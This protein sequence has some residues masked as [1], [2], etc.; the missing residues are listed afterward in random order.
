MWIYENTQMHIIKDSLSSLIMSWLLPFILYLI[1][2]VFRLAALKGEKS[3]KMFLYK[4][5]VL[6]ENVLG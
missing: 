5:S 4:I 1:P 2:G 3:N 6:L